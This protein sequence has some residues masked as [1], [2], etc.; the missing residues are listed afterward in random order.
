MISAVIFG[1]VAIAVPHTL[2]ARSAPSAPAALVLDTRP[3][4]KMQGGPFIVRTPAFPSSRSQLR[5][6]D[7]QS[8]ASL[9]PP[10]PRTPTPR[11]ALGPARRGLLTICAWGGPAQGVL[12]RRALLP[13]RARLALRHPPRLP[14]LLRRGTSPTPPKAGGPRPCSAPRITPCVR[15]GGGVHCA[16]RGVSLRCDRRSSRDGPRP[17]RRGEQGGAAL[18]S[19]L[20]VPPFSFATVISKRASSLS[21][22]AVFS[23]ILNRIS[24][25][26]SPQVVHSKGVRALDEVDGAR[27]GG[28][29]AAHEG[30]PAWGELPGFLLR[31]DEADAPARGPGAAWAR[32]CAAVQFPGAVA[33]RL[34]CAVVN[35]DADDGRRGWCKAAALCQAPPP[36]PP[37]R[38]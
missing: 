15:A 8:P 18:P 11:C 38:Y 30:S 16:V 33:M 10:P 14:H 6:A 17:R 24:L 7:A 34:S 19:S 26:V 35:P 20:R 31:R 25:S 21:L 13:R 22:I 2:P 32:F 12:A 23:L 36:P 5:A 37:P 29:L 28:A 3:S 9:P 27:R 4:V 1:L